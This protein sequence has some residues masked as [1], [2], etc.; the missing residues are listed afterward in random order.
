MLLTIAPF[1]AIQQKS[2][3]HAKYLTMY[4]TYL[5]LL[6]RFGRH[7]SGDIR[8]PKGRCNGIQSNL[9]DVRRCRKEVPLFFASVFDN[10]LADHKYAFKSIGKIFLQEFGRSAWISYTKLKIFYTGTCFELEQK[11]VWSQFVLI[12]LKIAQNLVSWFS[13]KS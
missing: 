11:I 12:L 10:G 13:G 7:I 1:A 3:Y 6:Y 2:A 5:D 4:W 8:S 9:E